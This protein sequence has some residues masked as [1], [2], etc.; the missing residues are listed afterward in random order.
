MGSRLIIEGN[1]VYEI[2]EDCLMLQKEKMEQ[3]RM[4]LGEKRGEG[5][6]DRKSIENIRDMEQ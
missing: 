3:E 4:V 1:A 5:E 6:K 2:D